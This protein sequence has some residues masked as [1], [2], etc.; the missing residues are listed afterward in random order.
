MSVSRLVIVTWY[1]IE[2]YYSDF[3]FLLILLSF[4]DFM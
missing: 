4:I 2:G 3:N 1:F